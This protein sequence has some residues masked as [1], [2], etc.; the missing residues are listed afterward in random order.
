MKNT[1]CKY[2]FTGLAIK[3]YT[4]EGELYSAWPCCMMG[5]PVGPEHN[6]N[7][8]NFDKKELQD[9]T[10][11]D[12]YNH[13]KMQ[14][15]RENLKN[16]VKD[17]ACEVCWDQEERGIKSFRQYANELPGDN[18]LNEKQ[19][20]RLVKNHNLETIDMSISNAC[21]LACRM[22]DTTASSKLKKDFNYFIKHNLQDDA[23][24][25]ISRW[26][27]KP[28]L[29]SYRLKDV[30][31]W[32]WIMDNGDKFKTL[33]LSGGEPFYN[34]DVLQFIDKCIDKG[35]NKTLTLEFHTNGTLFTQELLDKLKLFNCKLQFS[36]DG[37][38][39]VYEYIRYPQSWKDL[40]KSVTMFNDQVKSRFFE[41]SM[42]V[43]ICNIFNIPSYLEWLTN[44]NHSD[45]SLVFSEIYTNDRGVALYHLPIRLL[46][47]AKAEILEAGKHTYIPTYLIEQMIDDAILNNKENR[48]KAYTEIT[49]FDKS[50]NQHYKDYLDPRIVEWL[51][52]EKNN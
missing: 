26:A 43:Q 6:Q 33:R 38:H 34:K 28:N 19:M 18:I 21:N 30:S 3:Q 39:E 50:R 48:H 25:A 13:P 35:W 51:D 8:L 22:C 20:K 29:N 12:V 9:A 4:Q 16:G 10:P 23:A 1:F 14:K 44:L 31:Q 52:E 42:V 37:T 45:V 46:E 15:L 2:A 47:E 27:K 41:V 17:K 40:E 11:M 32:K 24:Y 7:R 49:L 5:N 36:I